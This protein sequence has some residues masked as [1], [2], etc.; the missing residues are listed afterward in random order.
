MNET[1]IQ[2]PFPL[3]LIAI[4]SSNQIGVSVVYVDYANRV[5]SLQIVSVHRWL[6]PWGLGY[7]TEFV[8][9]SDTKSDSQFSLGLKIQ[10]YRNR[11]LTAGPR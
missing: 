2:I 8:Q 10:Q 6:I 7:L 3:H 9:K 5:A 11:E 4:T 1:L